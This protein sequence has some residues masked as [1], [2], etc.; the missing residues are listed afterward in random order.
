MKKFGLIIMVIFLSACDSA[1]VFEENISLENYIWPAEDHIKFQTEITDTINEMNL[2]LNIRH[3]A[4]YPFSNL[5][6]F[7]ALLKPQVC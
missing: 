5:W 3:T 4:H 2:I 6:V 1:K 7:P